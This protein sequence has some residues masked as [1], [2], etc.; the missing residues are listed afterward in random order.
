MQTRVNQ[1]TNRSFAGVIF[2]RVLNLISSKLDGE[3]VY[4]RLKVD[5]DQ[6]SDRARSGRPGKDSMSPRFWA[7][8]VP[9]DAP[10]KPIST[11]PDYFR[12]DR[13]RKGERL[14]EFCSPRKR[15]GYRGRENPPM[16]R[17]IFRVE[18]KTE[19]TKLAGK[20]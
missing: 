15:S 4:R 5:L 6:A 14:N 19:N 10:P 7:N 2:R 8:K 17:R 3:C 18:T 20:K 12:L 13:S 9:V 16:R 1:R 11:P